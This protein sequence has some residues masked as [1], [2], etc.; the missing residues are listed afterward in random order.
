M[1]SLSSWVIGRR[2]LVQ[3][4][5]AL[6]T[7]AVAKLVLALV[8]GKTSSASTHTT[9]DSSVTSVVTI[10]RAAGRGLRARRLLFL[11]LVTVEETQETAALL[12][13]LLF[14]LLVLLEILLML[15]L[16]LVYFLLMFLLKLM[17]MFGSLLVK[18]L[19]FLGI[20]LRLRALTIGVAR[21]GASC[22]ASTSNESSVATSVSWAGIR[23]MRVLLP[24]S[25]RASGLGQ[26]RRAR[27]SGRS[28]SGGGLGSITVVRKTVPY[29]RSSS[30]ASSSAKSSVAGAVVRRTQVLAVNL[31]ILIGLRRLRAGR[32]S[33]LCCGVGLLSLASSRGV[34]SWSARTSRACERGN[35][36]VVVIVLRSSR[37]RVGSTRTGSSRVVSLLLHRGSGLSAAVVAI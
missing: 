22:S 3:E 17:L 33:Q 14:M 37:Y 1:K 29:G 27:L 32:L 24:L 19:L 13:L 15:L 7:T 23:V 25:E 10:L 8:L 11:G 18:L 26:R 6:V 12:L 31:G 2:I 36:R 28:G 21:S 9:S 30:Q 16:E 35:V 5:L 4:I 20:K 34:V